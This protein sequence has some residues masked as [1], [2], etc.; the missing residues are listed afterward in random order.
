VTADSAKTILVIEDSASTRQ[1]IREVLETA[2]YECLEACDGRSGVELLEQVLARV[3]PDLILM[4]INMPGLDGY[5]TT[6]KIKNLDGCRSIPI[7]AFTSEQEHDRCL[8]AGCDGF[9]QK[10]LDVTSF[11]ERVEAFLAG[12]RERLEEDRER[13]LLREQNARLVGRLED[14]ADEVGGAQARLKSYLGYLELSLEMAQEMAQVYDSAGLLRVFCQKLATRL[15]ASYCAI[16][17]RDGPDSLSLAGFHGPKMPWEVRQEV[18]LEMLPLLKWVVTAKEELV[19]SKDSAGL[20]PAEIKLLFPGQTGSVLL[21]PLSLK[22]EG[23]GILMLGSREGAEKGF[24]REKREICRTLLAQAGTYL[25]NVRL[26]ENINNMYVSSIYALATALDEKD[27]YTKNHSDK[28]T[29]YA[30]TI[31]YELGL[32]LE[33]QKDIKTAAMLHD[34]GKIGIPD[35][36]LL[37]PGKLTA[38]EFAVIRTHPVR[39]AR[40]IRNIEPLRGIIPIVEHHHERWDGRGYCSGLSGENIPLGARVLAIGDSYDAMTSDRTYRSR[41]PHEQALAE[42]KRCAGAQ[43]DPELVEVFAKTFEPED[44]LPEASQPQAPNLRA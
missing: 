15:K 10:P 17:L 20:G 32:P 37:K 4:D 3:C 25:E 28:V 40:I 5:E 8:A 22:G 26:I 9:I 36:I 30:M 14:M 31:T 43:F 23:L 29:Q 18:S 12:H 39:G 34:I 44:F 19:L 21:V 33:E 7:V 41:M 35:S 27:P 42:L 16:A 38:E 1:L 11:L 24:R 2:G 13:L 6:I